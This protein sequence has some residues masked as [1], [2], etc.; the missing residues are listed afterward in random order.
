MV[1]HFTFF[2]FIQTWMSVNYCQ[3]YVKMDVVLI[4]LEA[5]NAIV[6]QATSWIMIDE[7]VKVLFVINCY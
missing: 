1:A 7:S 6:P 4:R 5:L 3:I 2:F